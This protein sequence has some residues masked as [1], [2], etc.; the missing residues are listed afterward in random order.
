MAYSFLCTNASQTNVVL[1]KKYGNWQFSED[2]GQDYS[3]SMR[4]P[5]L[6]NDIR[7][8]TTDKPGGYWY[9]TLIQAQ[10]DIYG[11]GPLVKTSPARPVSE[12]FYWMREK[13]RGKDY[14]NDHIS[15]MMCV[16]TSN[17]K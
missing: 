15:I 9:G 17:L 14:H 10:R 5:W 3:F 16:S 4:M 7:L 13:T 12:V 2:I 8:L 6:D 11:V 1:H